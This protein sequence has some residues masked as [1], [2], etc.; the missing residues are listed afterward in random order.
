[1]NKLLSFLEFLSETPKIEDDRYYTKDKNEKS[2]A[3]NAIQKHIKDNSDKSENIGNGYHRT[4]LNDIH[5]YHRNVKGTPTEISVVS[6][7]HMQGYINKGNGDSSHIKNFM[8]HHA[9]EYGYIKSDSVQSSGS[10]KLWM[11]LIKEKDPNFT[12]HHHD[13]KTEHEIDSEYLKNNENKIWG[14][15]D[16]NKQHILI[17]RRKK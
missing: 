9:N 7:N 10:K 11:D 4:K 6:R 2:E 5:F 12:F 14:K 13:G 17:M 8:K 15:T 1:M 3:Y 16:D